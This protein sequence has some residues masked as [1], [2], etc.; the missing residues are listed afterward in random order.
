MPLH[1]RG[2]DQ[3]HPHGRFVISRKFIAESEV[4]S[5]STISIT[6]GQ[7]DGNVILQGAGFRELGTLEHVAV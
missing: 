4:E 5:V 6:D 2:W 3:F 7:E 1:N